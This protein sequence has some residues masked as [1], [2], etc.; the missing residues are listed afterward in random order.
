MVDTGL[1]LA[2]SLRAPGPARRKLAAHL[3]TLA[4]L[5][6]WQAASLIAPSYLLPGPAQVAR[7][8]WLFVTN[9]RDLGHLG[10]SLSHVATAIA[11]SFVIG[12]LLALIPYYL[13]LLRFAIERRVGPFLNSFSAIGWTLLSVMWFG[14]TPLTVIFAISAVLVPF[15]LVNMSAGLA[16]LDPEIIEMAGSFTRR[17]AR[18]FARVIVPSLYPFVFATLRIMFGVAWKVTL[19]AELF[20]GNAGLGYMINLARQEFDTATIFAA[21]IIIIGFV[22]GVDQY[23]LVPLQARVSRHYA[24]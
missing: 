13:P 11:I 14:V 4:F 5:A 2:P 3:F 6:A 7:R 18:M 20:G 10:A 16:N 8:L 21:I 24:R 15:A 12:A 1:A 22:H 17:R 19:T 9:G 23:V